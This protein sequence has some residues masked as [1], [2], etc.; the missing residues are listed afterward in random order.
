MVI[1]T[2]DDAR[3]IMKPTS[4]KEMVIGGAD[5]YSKTQI[6]SKLDGKQ[7]TLEAYVKDV[8]YS[9]S[10]LYV[11]DKDGTVTDY[12]IAGGGGSGTSDHSQLSNLD[13]A[14]SG[15]TGFAKEN[16]D[17][18]KNFGAK[19]L[20]ANTLASNGNA[21]I[22]GTV[23]ADIDV[24]INDHG[25]VT[26]QLSKKANATI[27][28]SK[29]GTSMEI[30]TLADIYNCETRL[31]KTY[32]SGDTIGLVTNGTF[33]NDYTS[34]LTFATG[35]TAPSI[36]YTG[37]GIIQWVGSECKIENGYSIF[38]PAANKTYDIV[39]YYNGT[40]FI[41]LVNGYTVA[42]SNTEE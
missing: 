10:K 19:V 37:T 2:D 34:G 28:T 40:Q 21:N 13:Y 30:V 1:R 5:T 26:H 18:S 20:T 23:N 41:G 11:T 36:D 38:A 33:E 29:T 8:T 7:D 27:I 16:G 9:S 22:G 32:V 31:T 25:T 15:H 12:T 17:S 39:F 4:S 6:D 24:V 14:H 35:D 42:T 3:I